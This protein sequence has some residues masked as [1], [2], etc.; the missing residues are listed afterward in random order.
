M[1]T[2]I[3]IVVVTGVL[4]YGT[5]CLIGAVWLDHSFGGRLDWI[6]WG[7]AIAFALVLVVCWWFWWEHVGSQIHVSFG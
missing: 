7:V 1:F 3:G 5:L 4:L 2:F 6:E